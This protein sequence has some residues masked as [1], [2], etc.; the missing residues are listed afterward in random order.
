MQEESRPVVPLTSILLK[1]SRKVKNR[2][3]RRLEK[4]HHLHRRQRLEGHHLVVGLQRRKAKRPS[5]LECLFDHFVLLCERPLFF[6]SST[7][8]NETHEKQNA[9]PLHSSIQA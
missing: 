9:K 3:L 2:T 4:E 8:I 5:K 1:E 7:R 6:F